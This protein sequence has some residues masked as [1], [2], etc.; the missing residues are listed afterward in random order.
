MSPNNLGYQPDLD[1]S[2]VLEDDQEKY[3]QTKVRHLRWSIEL[4]R[5]DINLEIAL[6]SWYLDQPRHGHIDQVFH[7][8]L[9]LKWHAKIKIVLE[10]FKNDFDG[11]FMAYYWQDFYVEVQEYLQRTRQKK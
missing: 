7:T 4:G 1:V 9:F 11:E 3:Y 5:I 2:L 8:L 6:L 10:I